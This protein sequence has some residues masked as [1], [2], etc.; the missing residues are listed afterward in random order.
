M[1]CSDTFN[2]DTGVISFDVVR[3]S[4]DTSVAS[5]TRF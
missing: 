1:H 5:V 3:L 4:T 2:H